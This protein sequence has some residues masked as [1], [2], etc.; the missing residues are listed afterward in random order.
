MKSIISS[1]GI[2]PADRPVTDLLNTHPFRRQT[3][4]L[5][6][7]KTT[8]ALQSTRH[9]NLLYNPRVT[10]D[11][12]AVQ[13]VVTSDR[14]NVCRLQRLRACLVSD[15]MY[16][17]LLDLRNADI[18]HRQRQQLAEEKVQTTK[19]QQTANGGT[20]TEREK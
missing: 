1:V 14:F 17:V 10:T 11:I 20:D 4:T 2:S 12:T 13:V 9:R 15:V 16:N 5:H 7:E 18:G 19:I 3:G 6:T 8:A